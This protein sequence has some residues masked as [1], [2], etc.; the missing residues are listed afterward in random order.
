MINRDFAEP[1]ASRSLVLQNYVLEKNAVATV[2]TIAT[3]TSTS[4]ISTPATSTP[5]IIAPK[6][7]SPSISVST[8][9]QT[10]TLT[11]SGFSPTSITVVRGQSIT[12][13]NN[14]SG[15]MWVAS[16]PFPSSSE[17]PD[18]NEKTG[19][20][21]GDSWTFTFGQS[22]TWFYHNH[23]SPATGAKVVVSWK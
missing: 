5:K 6:T 10:V 14:S 20:A 23:Y 2:A 22:G 1:S 18:F 8:S 13:V 3:S 21:N 12:F 7:I 15:K 17:Y 4:I 9:T 11:D 16:N 19:I